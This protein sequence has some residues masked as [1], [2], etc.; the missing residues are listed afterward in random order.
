M[1]KKNKKRS[2]LPLLILL[3]GSAMSVGIIIGALIAVWHYGDSFQETF[4]YMFLSIGVSVL[5][6][7]GASFWVL[8]RD[9]KFKYDK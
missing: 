7:A 3:T 2:I 9:F 5:G 8:V 6:A 4:T 1:E